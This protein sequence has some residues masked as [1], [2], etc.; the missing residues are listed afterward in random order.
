MATPS[1]RRSKT[2]AK[3]KSPRASRAKAKSI[4]GKD[5][6]RKSEPR[7]GSLLD[8]HLAF[9][10]AAWAFNPMHL[11]MQQQAAVWRGINAAVPG[12]QT[13]KRAKKKP[14]RSARQARA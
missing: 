10:N 1:K 3:T 5:P 4:S 14:T 6:V 2:S 8:A 9:L 7:Q 11:L 13:P 12:S